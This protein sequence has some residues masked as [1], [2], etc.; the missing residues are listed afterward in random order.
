MAD[1]SQ[2]HDRF[3]K[4]LLSN[5]ETAGTLLQERLPKEV[6]ELLSPEAPELVD[7]SFVDEELRAHLTDRLYL[8]KT[9]TGRTAL[10]YVLVEHKEFPGATDWLAATEIH[11]RGAE[12]MGTGAPGLGSAADHRALRLL[13]WGGPM[14]G[15]G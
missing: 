6:A 10:L 5:P 3:L 1:I 7:G 15:S 4:T 14:A 9:V 2:P 12:A 11:G 8:A 13:P